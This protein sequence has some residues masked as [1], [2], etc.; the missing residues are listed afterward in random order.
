MGSTPNCNGSLFWLAIVVL[1]GLFGLFA[2]ALALFLLQIVKLV[3]GKHKHQCED[4]HFNPHAHVRLLMFDKVCQ[5]YD[6]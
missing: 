5:C 4:P 3:N 1:G 2:F 6:A